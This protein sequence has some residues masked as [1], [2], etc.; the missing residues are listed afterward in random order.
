MAA[1]R[2]LTFVTG[3]PK[4]LEEVCAIVGESIPWCLESRDVDLPELQGEPDDIARDKCRLAAEKVGGPVITEDTCLCF[5]ALH[6]LPGPYIKWFL[7]KIGHEGLNNLL[8]AYEDKSAVAQCT[9]AF[10]QGRG[11]EVLL[12]HGRTPGRIVPA[13][14]PPAFGWD[15]IFQP[16]GYTKTYAELSAA[17]KN[18]IS[19]RSCALHS[20][21]TFLQAEEGEETP[22]PSKRPELD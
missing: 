4:K 20:L 9:F 21:R 16:E 22:P 7:T 13:R 10:C 19:H 2:T 5:N 14:G 18:A 15:P 17:E 3:N 1:R 8:A 11:R 12:F 6:G